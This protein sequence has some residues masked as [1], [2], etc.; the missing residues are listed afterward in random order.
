MVSQA[1]GINPGEQLVLE[2]ADAVQEPSSTTNSVANPDF[3]GGNYQKR[4]WQDSG[5]VST[6]IVVLRLLK[7]YVIGAM[8]P[9][10]T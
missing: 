2:L 7:D 5:G 9:I 6:Y 1:M 8:A 10:N 4:T 3:I